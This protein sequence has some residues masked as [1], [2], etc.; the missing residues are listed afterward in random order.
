MPRKGTPSLAACV[1]TASH[2]HDS[3]ILAS[4]S[5]GSFVGERRDAELVH[6]FI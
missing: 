3:R 4:E 5:L 1:N 2:Q 6:C